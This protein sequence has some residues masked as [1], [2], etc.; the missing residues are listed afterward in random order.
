MAYYIYTAWFVVFDVNTKEAGF[1][2]L[3]LICVWRQNKDITMHY[4]YTDCRAMRESKETIFSPVIDNNLTF[5]SVKISF[6][7]YI[8]MM[9]YILLYRHKFCDYFICRQMP[10]FTTHV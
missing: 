10:Y 4:K 1:S 7:N 9:T 3:F 8:H 2:G 5:T 6:Y